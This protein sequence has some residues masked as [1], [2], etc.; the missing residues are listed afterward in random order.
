MNSQSGAHHPKSEATASWF[1][2]WAVVALLV[3]AMLGSFSLVVANGLSGVG[4][5]GM[6]TTLVFAAVLLSYG[7]SAH[8]GRPIDR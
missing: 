8:A 6:V 1:V 2:Y 4:M 5:I 3:V 7:L